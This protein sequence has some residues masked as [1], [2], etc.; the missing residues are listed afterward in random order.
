MKMKEKETKT[1]YVPS[2]EFTSA[3]GPRVGE[4]VTTEITENTKKEKGVTKERN[5]RQKK[6]KPEASVMS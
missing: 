3:A 4:S 2:L 1:I 6:K 5:V